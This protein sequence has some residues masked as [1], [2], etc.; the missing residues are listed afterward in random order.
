MRSHSGLSVGTRTA[1]SK[2]NVLSDF[3]W[4]SAAVIGML[5]FLSH[6]GDGGLTYFVADLFWRKWRRSPVLYP[7]M[8]NVS[9]VG[10]LF[11]KWLYEYAIPAPFNDST[12]FNAFDMM[13]VAHVLLS[14]ILFALGPQ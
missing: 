3:C 2:C 12:P 1:P 14:L 13:R 10:W 8:N 4:Y 5:Y 7:K 9:Q 11:L 6:L